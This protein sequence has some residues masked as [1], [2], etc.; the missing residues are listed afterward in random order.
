MTKTTGLKKL[1]LGEWERVLAREIVKSMGMSFLDVMGE[2]RTYW[3]IR[4]REGR[5]QGF[6][7]VR[8]D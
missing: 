5:F 1:E 2:R 3:V 6:G 8:F 4:D 7:V